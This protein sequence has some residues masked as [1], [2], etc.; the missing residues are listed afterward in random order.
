MPEF[1]KS[2]TAKL[3]SCDNRLQRL[4]NEVIRYQDCTIACGHR[5]EAAQEAAFDAGFSKVHY[6]DS[7]H[8]SYPSMAVD[9]APYP[10]DWYNVEK[11][12]A[13]AVLVKECAGKLGVEVEWG[14]D[15]A[16]FRDYPHWQV[17]A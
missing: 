10:I 11:F 9:V 1:S 5:G 8:N 12:Q 16:D 15:W 14:G 4:F 7:K 13:F 17:K 2:S 3:E 6:P